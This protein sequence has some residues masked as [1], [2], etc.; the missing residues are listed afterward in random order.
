MQR[1]RLAIGLLT[2]AA[3]SGTAADDS[4]DPVESTN[5][6]ATPWSST[7]TLTYGSVWWADILDD[8]SDLRISP[9]R[10]IR[11]RAPR[12]GNVAPLDGRFRTIDGSDN[13]IYDPTMGAA[14]TPLRRLIPAAYE[15]GVAALA[16]ATRPSPRAISNMV[17]AQTHSVMNRANA[18]DMLWQWGQF[19]DHDIDLTDGVEP[20]EPANIPIPAG[21]IHFDSDGTGAAVIRFNRSIYDRASGT[22]SE[23]PRQ[24]INEITSWI[25][26][27]MVYGSDSERAYALRKMDGSGRL[28]TSKGRLLPFNK[29]ALPNAG[30]TDKSLFLAGDVRANE[31][32][33]LLSLHTL[34]VRE[35]NREARRIRKR[36]PWLSGD[37]IYELARQRV[38][39]LIQ[40]ITYREYLPALLGEH[41][42]A[43][44]GGYESNVDGRISNIFSGA[45]YRYGHSALSPVLQRIDAQGN[46]IEAGHLPLR[47]AFFSPERI[48]DEGGIEPVL[49]GLASQRCQEIDPYIVDDVRNFL[50][51]T[52]GHGG[53]DLASINIQ[54]GRDHGLPGY[55][56]V[57]VALGLTRKATFSEVTDDPELQRKL[58]SVYDTV[59]DIDLWVGGLAETPLPKAM[60]GELVAKVLIQQFEA[61]RDADRYWYERV[62]P[63]KQALVVERTRLADVIRRNTAI[64][65]EIRDDVF[66]VDGE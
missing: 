55:N 20:P 62:M 4:L 3:F 59:D 40:V 47:D 31:Q 10:G 12:F 46:A 24:Q 43:P 14:H 9:I 39:A 54:R 32:V 45:L 36:R 38:T 48:I 51:G 35:H 18:S 16:G 29:Q 49:R 8:F 26:A 27:S 33:G 19:L 15:D 2:A 61:L 17:S 52:P 5:E 1:F 64:G 11:W 22:S 41:A 23:N 60:V 50:F 42:L 63:R 34:F 65:D 37:R 13:N 7:E 56:D 44:Y 58:A 53:F 28:R 21:D 25:D 6:L 66:H 57:R 30:G